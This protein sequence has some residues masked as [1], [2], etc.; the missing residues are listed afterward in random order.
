MQVLLDSFI[1]DIYYKHKNNLLGLHQDI[2]RDL[3]EQEPNW[4]K[5][6]NFLDLSEEFYHLMCPPTFHD[7]QEELMLLKEEDKSPKD[8]DPEY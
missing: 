3:V 7:I 8:F 6:Y 4:L 5:Y 1:Q 2:Q